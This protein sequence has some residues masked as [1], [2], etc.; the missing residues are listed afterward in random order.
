MLVRQKS[1]AQSG[2]AKE[3]ESRRPV[4]GRAEL[5]S[6]MFVLV[7]TSCR[8]NL[9]VGGRVSV[10]S[11]EEVC[12]KAREGVRKSKQCVSS[13]FDWERRVKN[14]GSVEALRDLT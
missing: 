8:A 6:R 11:S 4:R 14:Q 5:S 3:D 2:R 9:E 10:A 1:Q 12:L 13:E 7:G